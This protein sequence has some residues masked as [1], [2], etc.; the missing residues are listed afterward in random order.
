MQK[1]VSRRYPALTGGRD[2]GWFSGPGVAE[3]VSITSLNNARETVVKQEI[4]AYPA[5]APFLRV[6]VE[7]VPP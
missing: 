6:R 1:L 2:E 7:L 4:L 3:I 5:P